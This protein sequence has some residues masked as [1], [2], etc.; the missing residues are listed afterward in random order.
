MIHVS[1]RFFMF[2]L[3]HTLATWLIVQTITIWFYGWMVC[4]FQQNFAMYR[5][6]YSSLGKKVEAKKPNAE[7]TLASFLR[8]HLF[9]TGTK[10]GCSS[11]GCGSCTVSVEDKRTSTPSSIYSCT[12]KVPYRYIVYRLPPSKWN[13]N[14]SFGH[15]MVPSSLPLKA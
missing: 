14:F 2:S 1:N 5:L 8:N 3:S 4:L 10:L 15:V 6:I 7:T 11:S 12:T 9:L 13:Y